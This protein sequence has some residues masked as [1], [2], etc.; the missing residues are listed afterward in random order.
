MKSLCQKT[1]ELGQFIKEQMKMQGFS[2]R[3]L[4]L[5]AEVDKMTIHSVIKNYKSFKFET[6]ERILRSLGF[7]ISAI[8]NEE[9]PMVRVFE[10]DLD[11]L[12][13][14]NSDFIC[15]RFP[16]LKSLRD[17]IKESPESF[18]EEQKTLIKIMVV[19]SQVCEIAYA[20]KV[21]VEIKLT[22]G[23]DISNG[24]ETITLTSDKNHLILEYLGNQNS[25][26]GIVRVST[27]STFFSKAIK[28]LL[29]DTRLYKTKKVKL[30][31]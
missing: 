12:M 14:H 27:D 29:S 18:S 9:S 4:A 26:D 28:K 5:A 25:K 31:A 24:F 13:D 20:D 16:M 22:R 6:I 21:R 8:Y 30:S 23:I 7:T 11:Q 17:N 19:A 1:D 2:I 3:S 10:V 15:Q